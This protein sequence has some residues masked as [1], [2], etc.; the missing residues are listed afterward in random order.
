MEARSLSALFIATSLTPGKVLY[1]WWV[2][3]KYWLKD[4]SV[5]VSH[6]VWLVDFSGFETHIVKVKVINLVKNEWLL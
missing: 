4:K 5:N 1:K 6:T 3:N 2:L